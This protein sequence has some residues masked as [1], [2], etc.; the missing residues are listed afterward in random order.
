MPS[1]KSKEIWTLII[2]Y[3]GISKYVSYSASSSGSLLPKNQN[4]TK[5]INRNT[6]KIKSCMPNVASVI[7]EISGFQRITQRWTNKRMPEEGL[8]PLSITF[9]LV[10]FN[11]RCTGRPPP[12]HWPHRATRSKR[13]FTTTCS[14]LN[15]R[16]IKAALSVHLA[17]EKDK[18]P[19]NS[20]RR[21]CRRWGFHQCS[22]TLATSVLM[23]KKRSNLIIWQD[24]AT[25]QVS[26][27]S[28]C[29]N[30]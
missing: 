15:A 11:A 14:L 26:R 8:M 22:E 4:W 25:K 29:C 6:V 13:G 20:S 28:K 17:A 10:I 16:E 24:Q 12:L 30:G 9:R 3:V 18:T 21:S 2:S 7:K 1:C 27:K 23:I 5:S 19:F